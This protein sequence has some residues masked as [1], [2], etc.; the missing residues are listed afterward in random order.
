MRILKKIT[1]QDDSVRILTDEE[2]RAIT[3]F[4]YSSGTGVSEGVE[5]DSTTNRCYAQ[6]FCIDGDKTP[7]VSC[8][9]TGRDC[10]LTSVLVG[11]DT[12]PIGVRCNETYE[13]CDR[14][15][16]PSG[17]DP[18]AI[19][20][21]VQTACSGKVYQQP[22]AYVKGIDIIAGRCVYPIDPTGLH[23]L[24]CDPTRER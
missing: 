2:Q 21:D 7:T 18:G 14:V 3:V 1:F 20:S 5:Y 12:Y 8:S 19:S 24:Y 4:D 11:N 22:C 10:H 9:G 6:R 16:L 13:F 15:S 23:R 17:F